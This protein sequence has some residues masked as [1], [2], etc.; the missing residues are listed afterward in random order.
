MGR[1]LASVLV[2]ISLVTL[3]LPGCRTADD[4]AGLAVPQAVAIQGRANAGEAAANA[5]APAEEVTVWITTFPRL[6]TPGRQVT[7]TG[8]GFAGG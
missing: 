1:F 4:Q 6:S 2:S 5:A 8:Q 3:A 7:L